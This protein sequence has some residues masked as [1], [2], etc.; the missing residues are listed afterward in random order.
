[1]TL[2]LNQSSDVNEVEIKKISKS[3][4]EAIKYLHDRKI[5]HCDIKPENV[6]LDE[7]LN[8][9]LIDFGLSSDLNGE[10][11]KPGGSYDYA[12]LKKLILHFENF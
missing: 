10:Y 5:A 2:T 12:A 3:I 1:M 6:L 4:A 9:K 11:V 7:N 8:P